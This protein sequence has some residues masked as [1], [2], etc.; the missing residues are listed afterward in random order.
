MFSSAYIKGHSHLK[1]DDYALHSQ[2]CAFLSDG[3]SS[4]FNSDIG[5]KLLPYL[6]TK[7][8]NQFIFSLNVNNSVKNYLNLLSVIANEKF[9]KNIFACTLGGI[10]IP[11]WEN[12]LNFFLL[13]DGIIYI[14]LNSGT[15]YFYKISYSQN[16]PFYFQ[17]Y[18][19]KEETYLWKSYKENIKLNELFYMENKDY[20]SINNDSD[21]IFTGSVAFDTINLIA[22]FSDGPEQVDN[23]ELHEVLKE[24]TDFKNYTP[25]FAWRRLKRFEETKRKEGKFCQDDISMIV[26]KKD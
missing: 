1:C 18:M 12:H 22:I 23:S 3:C 26:Y 7:Y 8:I 19:D 25:D 2:N 6:A 24:L 5:S 4:V 20:I 13:G 10:I 14:E 9:D 21:L 15:K 16:T 17:Y 11:P